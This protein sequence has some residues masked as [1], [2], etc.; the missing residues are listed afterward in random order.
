MQRLVTVELRLLPQRVLGTVAVL[1][2]EDL[3]G[4]VEDDAVEPQPLALVTE[5]RAAT[6]RDPA[7]LAV[8]VQNPVL[9][10]VRRPDLEGAV[11]LLGHVGPVVWMDDGAVGA[12]GVVHE[13]RGGEAAD[14]LDVVADEA[15]R[16][17]VAAGA[18]IHRARNVGDD[19]PE[20]LL[21]DLRTGARA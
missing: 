20:L 10:G 5:D 13:V 3:I 1:L 9:E 16:P 6:L 14:E 19:G 15:D 7:H 8:G 11:D 17:V 18:A 12:D 4:D 21:D 2:G